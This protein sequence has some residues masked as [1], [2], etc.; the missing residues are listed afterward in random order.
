MPR[1]I[2]PIM[3]SGKTATVILTK[4]YVATIDAADVAL[5]DGWNWHAS[6]R[7]DTVYA[8]RSTRIGGRP[9]GKSKAIYLHRFLMDAPDG[10][11][12]DHISGDGLDNRR[13]N[14]RLA[15][16]TQNAQNQ[17]RRRDNTVG[18]KGVWRCVSGLKWRAMIQEGGTRKH[19]G[20]F[21]T[22]EAAHAAYTEA[23]NRLWGEFAR[24]A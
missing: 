8:G 6:V 20:Y 24:A 5:V 7:L 15:T 23:A 9:N 10:L 19:L 14:L 22:P 12:V 2:R 1:K 21:T 13:D 3:V 17:R 16:H 4:G 18:F 11:E